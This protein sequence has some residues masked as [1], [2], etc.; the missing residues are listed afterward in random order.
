MCLPACARVRVSNFTTSGYNRRNI[1]QWQYVLLIIYLLMHWYIRTIK[2]TTLFVRFG[3]L[4]YVIAEWLNFCSVF[5]VVV[6]PFCD[7]HRNHHM[8]FQSFAFFFYL[9]IVTLAANGAITFGRTCLLW[10]NYSG[11]KWC[12]RPSNEA[13][14]EAMDKE[15]FIHIYFSLLG[16]A[17][18]WFYFQPIWGSRWP[19]MRHKIT[20]LREERKKKPSI[21]PQMNAFPFILRRLM[22]LKIAPK[23]LTWNKLPS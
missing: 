4:Y 15:P 12:L 3:S 22:L 23:S 20:I 18:R 21:L 8:F 9:F 10:F 6:V 1:G 17:Q 7:W 5:V 13:E 2:S 14:R 16:V 19:S 11:W